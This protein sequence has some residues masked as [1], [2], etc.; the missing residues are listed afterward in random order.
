MPF[1]AR[2]SAQR[3]ISCAVSL[4]HWYSAELGRAAPGA[5]IA[6]SFW[7]DADAAEAGV[8]SGA[9][10]QQLQKYVAVFRA[11]P[12]REVYDVVVADAPAVAIH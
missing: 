2:N 9:Y 8:V 6:V 11:P 3:E 1:V 12:G 5:E 7:R 4:A 10:A